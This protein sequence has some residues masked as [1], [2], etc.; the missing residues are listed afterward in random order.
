V[1][2]KTLLASFLGIVLLSFALSFST[3]CGTPKL[4]SGG[5]YSQA[6]QAPDIAFYVTDASFVLAYATVDAAFKIE[7]DNRAALW[8]LSPGIKRTL[9]KVRPEAVQVVQH[10][11]EARKAYL[12]NPTPIGLT[13]L[14]LA[15]KRIEDLSGAVLAVLPKK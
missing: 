10:Y 3:G 6:N 11:G 15:L 12:A 9:D 2:L 7:R 4:E 14:N 1:K 5:A 13:G 8:R